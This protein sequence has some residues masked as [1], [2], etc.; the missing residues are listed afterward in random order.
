MKKFL[1]NSLDRV[2]VVANANTAVDAVVIRGGL[3]GVAMHNAADGTDL[4]IAISGE[5]ELAKIS[6]ASTSMA[7]GANVYW[8]AT[9]SQC[10]VSATSNTLI[11]VATK[12]AANTD[13]T[14]RVLLR[15]AFP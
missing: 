6:A 12:A 10:T 5:F 7:V 9:N 2:T 4:T 15:H 13:T 8:D 1:S 14:V 3:I 11:G